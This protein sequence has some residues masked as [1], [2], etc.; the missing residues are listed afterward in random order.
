MF[1]FGDLHLLI[2]IVCWVREYPLLIHTSSDCC[3]IRGKKKTHLNK[4]PSQIDH[5]IPNVILL[6]SHWTQFLYS[7]STS[8]SKSKTEIC[9]D[10]L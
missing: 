3:V 8:F 9:K 5:R 1:C 2:H 10:M 4:S 7:K 6:N